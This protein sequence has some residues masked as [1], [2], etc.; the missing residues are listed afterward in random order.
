MISGMDTNRCELKNFMGLLNCDYLCSI[1]ISTGNF[2]IVSDNGSLPVDMGKG[3]DY[4]RCIR[5]YLKK[6]AVSDRLG[7]DILAMQ[8]P[9]II[10]N[11]ETGKFY[12]Y[13]IDIREN[14]KIRRKQIR[15][16]YTDS[17]KGLVWQSCM[18]IEDL[19][20]REREK[21]II[22]EQQLA[23]SKAANREKS[24]LLLHISHDIRTSI[25]G[26]SGMA[27]MA[28]E[29][30][31]EENIQ[32]YLEKIER[33]SKFF[34]G[35]LNDILD[36]ARI[37]SG[38][39]GLNREVLSLKEFEE[40]M[41]MMLLP[42]LEK[43]GVSYEYRNDSSARYVYTDIVRFQQI[44]F[45]LLS[46]AVKYTMPGGKVIFSQEY[47]DNG[48]HIPWMRFQVKDTGIGMSREFLERAFEPFEQEQIYNAGES[49][50]GAGL[51]LPIVKKL[52]GMMNGKLFME[53]EQGKGTTV[54]VDLPLQHAEN[55]EQLKKEK[56]TIQ[57][58]VLQG[59]RVLVVEDNDI[60]LLVAVYILEKN[61][62]FVETAR[63]GKEAFEAVQNS[64]ENY[65][66][67]IL[68]DV[69]MPVT[70]GL[71][72]TR[73]IRAMAR[74][75]AKKIPIIAMSAN[76]YDEELKK[77]LLAGMNAHLVKPVEPDTL[78][79]TLEEYLL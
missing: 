60:N 11:L 5:E 73:S 75:D 48:T 25:S 1:D 14:G 7:Q 56:R 64:D 34:L 58:Q 40:S 61:G 47:L 66:D 74:H 51:G 39:M 33:M 2:E 17:Q 79:A 9:A 10:R 23:Q 44:F 70:D 36:F 4:D 26:V 15:Y 3:Q 6:N 31:T 37:E 62:M 50:H 22:L 45:N 16:T 52:V 55:K 35:L 59:K 24:K 77:A 76:A 38:N 68:M 49:W 42:M 72:A 29:K 20:H 13:E 57:S 41:R 46:N 19:V 53:S 71:T 69:R 43:Q 54:T 63:N 27:A 8:I 67:A 28:R 12:T 21:T 78:L 32:D 18:D 65:Y 30:C